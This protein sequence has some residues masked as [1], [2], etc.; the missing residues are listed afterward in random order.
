M[1]AE[2]RNSLE[3]PERPPKPDLPVAP[4]HFLP[5]VLPGGT[6]APDLLN[7]DVV[8]DPGNLLS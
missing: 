4:A 7:D 5:T 2:K 6:D 8:G 1:F 3:K